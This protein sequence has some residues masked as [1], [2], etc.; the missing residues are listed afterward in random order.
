MIHC[1]FIKISTY[2]Y[3]RSSNYTKFIHTVWEKFLSVEAVVSYSYHCAVD[4]LIAC[5]NKALK[6]IFGSAR[7]VTIYTE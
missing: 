4:V 1:A 5:K 7:D 2:W 3:F 6:K